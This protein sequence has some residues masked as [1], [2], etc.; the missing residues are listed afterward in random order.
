M[1]TVTRQPTSNTSPNIGGT[2][3]VTDAANTGHG[4][5]ESAATRNT[6]GTTTTTKTCRWSAF[7]SVSGTILGITLKLNWEAS[8]SVDAITSD[9]G[10]TASA[11][12]GLTIDYS[13]DGGSNWTGLVSVGT[14]ASA[15][16]GTSDSDTLDDSGSES[17]SIS[18]AISLSQIQVRDRIE[19]VAVVSEDVAATASADITATISGIQ[20]EVLTADTKHNLIVVL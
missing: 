16:A 7:Q 17:V 19:A 11:D 12:I 10:D 13:T 4:A 15:T 6:D 1:G 2:S 9:T 5:T 3:A 14:Q 20:L 18:S 8:G